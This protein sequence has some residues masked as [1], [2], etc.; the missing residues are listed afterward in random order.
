MLFIRSVILV[1]ISFWGSAPGQWTDAAGPDIKT[2][3]VTVDHP[4][5]EDGPEEMS[6]RQVFEGGASSYFFLEV[7]SVLCADH[8][9]MVVPVRLFWD[10]YG[11]YKRYELEPGV[12]LE[13]GEGL[14][15]EKEDYE[16]L[17]RILANEESALRE[18]SYADITQTKVHG[19]VDA[20]SGATALILSD[21]ESIEG[22]TWTCFTLW[23]WVHGEMKTRI[24]EAYALTLEQRQLREMLDSKEE[25]MK[26]FAYESL[27]YR[28]DLEEDT[29]WALLAQAPRLTLEEARI[30][31]TAQAK[32]PLDFRVQLSQSLLTNPAEAVRLISLETIDKNEQEKEFKP[33]L[34]DHLETISSLPEADKVLNILGRYGPLMS[35]EVDAMQEILK[36]KDLLITRRLFYFLQNQ[37]LSA[38]QQSVMDDFYRQNSQYL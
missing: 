8:I 16:Q 15:F 23:H 19:E 25:E 3:A 5:L 27:A 31:C 21:Q 36:E 20:M 1:I 7:E 30:I 24:R 2:I 28:E 11:R 18:L 10:N 33:L 35:T 34:F 14:P 22:A 4:A 29:E 38:S 12:E 6:L 32:W 13:K 17:D 37:K 9:C 26:L